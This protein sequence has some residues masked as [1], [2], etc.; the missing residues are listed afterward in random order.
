MAVEIKFNLL[1]DPE[2]FCRLESPFSLFQKTPKGIEY[3]DNK[4]SDFRLLENEP[5]TKAV[6]LLTPYNI[7]KEK[8]VIKS[9]HKKLRLKTDVNEYLKKYLKNYFYDS[10]QLVAYC[11]SMGFIWH[12]NKTSSNNYRITKCNINTETEPVLSFRVEKKARKLFIRTFVSIENNKT[13][14]TEMKRFLFLIQTG[15]IYYILKKQEWFLLEELEQFET[16][17]YELFIEKIQTK[18]KKYETDISGIFEEEIRET[19]PDSLIQ[20]SELG[21]NLLLFIPKWNYDGNIVDDDTDFFEIYDRNKKI[22]YIRNKEIERE[23]I[24][25]LQNAH[26]KFENKNSFYLTFAE[27][28]K[29]NWFFH[30]YHEELKDNYNVVGMDMLSYFRYSPHAVETDFKIIKTIDNEVIATF[31]TNFGK[32]IIEPKSLQRAL[33]E[34]KKFVLLKDNSLGILTDEWL[35]Q[36]AMILRYST[37]DKDEITFA[38]WILIVAEDLVSSHKTMRLILPEDWMKKWENWNHTDETLYP[39]SENIQ[40]TLRN[41]Q[42]KGY[43]WLNLMAEVNAGTL[44]ADDMGLGKTIQTIASIV[45]WAEQNP[46][47][48]FLIICPASLI[49]NWKNEF[50]KFAPVIKLGIHHGSDREFKEFIES[51]NQVLI[52]SYSI[53]RNDIDDFVK[54]VWDAV[55]LDESHHIKNLRTR[56]TQAVL[57]LMGKRRI[58]LNGTPIMNN[59]SDLYPQL[60]FLLPQLFYS[61]KKFKDDFEKPIQKSIADDQTQILKKLTNPFILRR[62]KEIAAPDL[63]PKIESVMWCEM[64]QDQLQAYKTL[65]DQV[66]QNIMTGISDKGLNNAKLDV[67]QGITKLRQMCSSPRLVKGFGDFDNVSSVKIDSLT[68]AL[69]SNLK[70]NKV[71][72]FSQFLGTMDLLSKVFDENGIQYLSFS[73]STP[74]AKRIELINEFQDENSEIQVFLLSLMAGNS[75]IN[76]TQANYVFLVEPWWNKA[77]QQQAINRVH[78]IGQ[79]QHVF[80]Y[81]MI[82]KDTIEE[83]II[84]LQNKKQIISDEVINTDEG[85]VKNLSHED[86][87]FLF[88]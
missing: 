70:D 10:F 2:C 84:E 66:R 56:Q 44:L 15:D 78:R 76:L 40:T 72:V 28:S 13:E 32:E 61:E 57:K 8:N 75:G 65:K 88:D 37:I 1:F 4:L 22:I 50:E 41:Y 79:N 49:Y 60:H 14:L 35:Q 82:C 46:N 47:S 29:K 23:T 51:G 27:A 34:N 24:R 19:N 43:E 7:S 11:F 55:V 81:N 73:G 58:I 52:S 45:Y 17:S 31:K 36:Y 18:L 42:R 20:I 64:N 86:I 38:K 12:K 87:A 48:R 39:I 53:I 25:F 62:T 67:L 77:V 6:L 21:G 80:A 16:I 9:N 5:E 69:T 63:P 83:K 59:V 26:P 85:F 30:F 71:I 68:E 3:Y 74:A 54:I 33:N